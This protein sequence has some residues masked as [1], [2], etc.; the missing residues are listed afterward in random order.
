MAKI[1]KLILFGI[2]IIALFSR[3][4]KLTSV[5]PAL[6]Q[7]EAVNGYDAYTLGI[8]LKDHHGN[9][10]PP[11]LE[12]FGDWASPLITYVTVPFVKIFGL[13]LFSIRLV[14]V[15]LNIA[16]V[17]LLFLLLNHLFKKPDIALLGTFLFSICP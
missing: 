8:S 16:S 9:F 14:V 17:Y 7:D 6:N 1:T 3:T 12:S 4:F 11:M 5:P 2:L 15:L 13:S 10:L